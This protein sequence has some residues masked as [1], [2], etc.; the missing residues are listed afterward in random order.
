MGMVFYPRYTQKRFRVLL[1]NYLQPY[2]D[3][4]K[5]NIVE[6]IEKNIEALQKEIKLFN[7][8][9]LTEF[10]SDF[11]KQVKI[12]FDINPAKPFKYKQMSDIIMNTVKYQ[13]N[14]CFFEINGKLK[15]KTKNSKETKTSDIPDRERQNAASQIS[16]QNLILFTTKPEASNQESISSIVSSFQVYDVPFNVYD[17]E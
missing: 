14:S 8:K 9:Q 16:E 1:E 2:P 11:I 10:K 12:Q 13:L 6:Y 15:S 7:Q 4:L 3:E 5:K 17:C